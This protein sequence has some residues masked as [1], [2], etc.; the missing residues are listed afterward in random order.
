MY[1]PDTD[2]TFRHEPDGP[3]S[4]VGSPRIK[5]VRRF[6]Y[7]FPHGRC[8]ERWAMAHKKPHQL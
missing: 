6:D 4:E 2:S 8:Q 5:S 3:L 7:I 1:T